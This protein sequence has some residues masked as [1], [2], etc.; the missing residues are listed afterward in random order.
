MDKEGDFSG[1]IPGEHDV[2]DQSLSNSETT[3]FEIQVDRLAEIAEL[4]DS[5]IEGRIQ[6]LEKISGSIRTPINVGRIRGRFSHRLDF[7]LLL[8]QTIFF[9]GPTKSNIMIF[10]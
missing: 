2:P 10:A 9:L 4:T 3:G 6:L 7:T 1:E 8:N 5:L